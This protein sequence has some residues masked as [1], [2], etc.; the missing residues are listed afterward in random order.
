MSAQVNP[1][2]GMQNGKQGPRET[3]FLA[4]IPKGVPTCSS[5]DF[6]L[7]ISAKLKTGKRAREAGEEDWGEDIDLS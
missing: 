2:V 1:G 5:A 4:P 7:S 3:I 6:C